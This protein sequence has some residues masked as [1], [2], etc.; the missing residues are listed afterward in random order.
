MTPLLTEKP[1][2]GEVELLWRRSSGDIVFS[3]G[4]LVLLPEVAGQ[5]ARCCPNRETVS[6]GS[7]FSHPKGKGPWAVLVWSLDTDFLLAHL[8]RLRIPIKRTDSQGTLL[9]ARAPYGLAGHFPCWQWLRSAPDWRFHCALLSSHHFVPRNVQVRENFLKST[10]KTVFYQLLAAY[11]FFSFFFLHLKL[12]L[13]LCGSRQDYYLKSNFRTKI[14]SLK[15]SVFLKSDV[16]FVFSTVKSSSETLKTLLGFD[17]DLTGKWII[18]PEQQLMYATALTTYL[19]W[20]SGSNT[21]VHFLPWVFFFKKKKK[22]LRCFSHYH[23][24]ICPVT[25]E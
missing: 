7:F 25:H 13:V 11:V 18:K 24:D 15:S 10:S 1:G 23:L 4:D 16:A 3:L 17:S 14:L 8:G 9:P 2:G 6:S 21:V 20:P 22:S 19:D 5:G 12:M